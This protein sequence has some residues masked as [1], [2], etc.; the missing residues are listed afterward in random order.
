V[1]A[2]VLGQVAGQ[3]GASD[4]IFSDRFVAGEVSQAPIGLHPRMTDTGTL[5]CGDYAYGASGSHNNNIDCS[6]PGDVDGDV[7]PFGQDGHYGEDALAGEPAFSYVKITAD[8]QPIDDASGM[9]ACV[10]DENTNLIWLVHP[11][12]FN[13]RTRERYTWHD[14]NPATNGGDPGSDS[15]MSTSDLIALANDPSQPMCGVSN[16]RLPTR[17]ELRS[18][19]YF[20]FRPGPAILLVKIDIRFFGNVP[21]EMFWTA[22][23]SPADSSRAAGIDFLTGGHATDFKTNTRPAFLVAND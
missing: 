11:S 12:G 4:V 19:V 13:T 3:S 2:L 20:G 8:G 22:L 18:L 10:R 23:T 15:G 5:E 16:W 9:Y 17:N 14:P 6:A 21:A 1:A 7:V